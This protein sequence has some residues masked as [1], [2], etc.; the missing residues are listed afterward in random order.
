MNSKP[1]VPQ[2]GHAPELILFVLYH[3]SVLPVHLTQCYYRIS[4]SVLQ[5]NYLYFDYHKK[6]VW[7][8]PVFSTLEIYSAHH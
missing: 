6:D 3:D 2:S 5:M 1:V 7:I 8:F 4:F